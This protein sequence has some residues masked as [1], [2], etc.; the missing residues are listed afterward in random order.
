MSRRLERAA[1]LDKRSAVG[2]GG[3]MGVALGAESGGVGGVGLRG[4]ARDGKETGGRDKWLK[5]YPWRETRGVP[6][7]VGGVDVVRVLGCVLFWACCPS[8]SGRAWLRG[9]LVK[10]VGKTGVAGNAFTAPSAGCKH[11]QGQPKIRPGVVLVLLFY[12]G[13]KGDRERND[14]W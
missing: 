5:V 14:G 13:E 4:A 8:V 3:S 12:A 1:G 6:T 7:A 10:T 9:Q 2:V 11:G